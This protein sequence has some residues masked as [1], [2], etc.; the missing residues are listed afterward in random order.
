ML[1]V[2]SR[3][4]YVRL[5]T[6]RNVTLSIA[7]TWALGL[8]LGSPPYL[9]FGGFAYNHKF[10]A[11]FVKENDSESWMFL[12]VVIVGCCFCPTLVITL[13]CYLLITLTTIRS[14]K[15]V[16]SVESSGNSNVP[17]APVSEQFAQPSCPNVHSL[18]YPVPVSDNDT[19][20]AVFPNP[21]VADGVRLAVQRQLTQHNVNSD[22]KHG[23]VVHGRVQVVNRA[24]V[25]VLKRI[26]AV[27][28]VFFFCWLPLTMFVMFDRADG[29]SALAMH[30]TFVISQSNSALNPVVYFGVG[31]EFRQASKALIKRLRL[32]MWLGRTM[33]Y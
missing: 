1:V 4:L 30:T 24:S 12:Q 16:Q 10:G 5:Y 14:L 17:I 18:S 21:A 11:C 6:R 26:I 13:Y 3:S 7:A 27:W 19:S 28:I 20:S 25:A 15:R 31:R 2:R 23:G 22:H 33:T 29:V 9:G 8:L 32:R